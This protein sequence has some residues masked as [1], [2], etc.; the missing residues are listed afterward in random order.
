MIPA[1]SEK[2][3]PERSTNEKIDEILTLVREQSAA[4]AALPE[5]LALRQRGDAALRAGGRN[6]LV[7]PYLEASKRPDPQ[8]ITHAYGHTAGLTFCGK[9]TE[10]VI[11][12]DSIYGWDSQGLPGWRRDE[13][14][15]NECLK[16]IDAESPELD[17][18]RF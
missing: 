3:I 4:T 13:I 1:V 7:S 10:T 15:C 2:K 17:K 11:A 8:T 5:R 16:A 6:K 12:P 18:L 14:S 9:R